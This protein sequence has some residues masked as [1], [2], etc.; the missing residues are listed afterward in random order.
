MPLMLNTSTKLFILIVGLFLAASCSS[1][2]AQNANSNALVHVNP[3]ATPSS[4]F[5]SEDITKLKW[6]EGT[7]RG[8]D[9]DKP[10]YE[11]YKIVESTMI[12]ET[13]NEDG[14]VDGDPGRFE[15][16]RGEFGQ[17]EGDK[18]SAASEISDTFV[19]FVPAKI[20]S[21]LNSFRFTKESDGT[22]TAL[23]EWPAS[24]TK[25]AGSKRYRMQ[26]WKPPTN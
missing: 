4:D 19:Q 8:M 15:L 3:M 1:G 23:L 16:K 17:G 5:T 11:R 10:F 22:W 13:L 24:T 12:V 26:P 20:G 21:G 9:G 25:P 2:D 14:T 7:W 6:I 18:R